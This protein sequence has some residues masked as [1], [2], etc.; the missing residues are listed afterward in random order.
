MKPIKEKVEY[1]GYYLI[2][3]K[4]TNG[5]EFVIP[6]RGYNLKS[7]LAFEKSLIS[8]LSAQHRIVSEAEFMVYHWTKTKW[9]GETK[10]VKTANKKTAKV[11]K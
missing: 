10:I 11:K 9:V 1:D 5:H 2:D 6:A 7:W 3:V 8:V 4:T